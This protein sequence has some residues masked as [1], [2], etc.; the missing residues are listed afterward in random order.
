MD[1][2]VESDNPDLDA[3]LAIEKQIN[4][5]RNEIRK[6]HVKSLKIGKYN[7]QTGLVYTDL[8]H[9]CERIGDHAINISESL[10]R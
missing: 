6:E 10:S 2:N 8:I 1:K 9:H 7:H 5:L 3:A 4:D